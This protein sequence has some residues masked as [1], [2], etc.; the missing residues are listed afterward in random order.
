MKSTS[1]DTILL[2]SRDDS[3]VEEGMG[4]NPLDFRTTDAAG[5][6]AAS[7]MGRKEGSKRVALQGEPDRPPTPEEQLKFLIADAIRNSTDKETQLA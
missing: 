6:R 4:Y 2:K 5:D 3:G 1:R 7:L